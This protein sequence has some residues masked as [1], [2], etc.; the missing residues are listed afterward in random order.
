MG[1]IEKNFHKGDIIIKEGHFANCFYIIQ[2]GAVE[3]IKRKGI[4]DQP[5]PTLSLL[6]PLALDYAL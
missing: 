1:T 3:V 5:T 2:E 4:A 6:S